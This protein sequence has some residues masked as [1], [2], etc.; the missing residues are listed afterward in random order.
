MTVRL[1]DDPLRPGWGSI[2]V[3]S[4]FVSGGMALRY[5]SG[6][7][8]TEYNAAA[9]LFKHRAS[10]QALA[11]IGDP[12]GVG[13]TLNDYH[14]AF[15]IEVRTLSGRVGTVAVFG[16]SRSSG[17]GTAGN[18]HGWASRACS[19]LNAAGVRLGFENHGMASV[20]S[21]AYVDRLSARLALGDCPDV[22]LWQVGSNNDAG[23][24]TEATVSAQI[25][26]MLDAK[27]RVEALGGVFVP[28]T[29]FPS[30]GADTADKVVQ[31]RRLNDAARACQFYVDFDVSPF[32]NGSAI[33]V[34]PAGLTVDGVHIN[35]TWQQVLANYAS[36]VIKA[37]IGI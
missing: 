32:N 11:N 31:W 36:P 15:W 7:G 22:V 25:A 26:R 34:L 33:P 21:S 6:V 28:V 17:F 35:D 10:F 1:I 9:P 3:R 12:L 29:M 27:E 30:S 13:A 37:A 5:G 18:Q 14:R 20:S 19:D 23:A 16:D 24:W 2:Y 8:Q 4:R